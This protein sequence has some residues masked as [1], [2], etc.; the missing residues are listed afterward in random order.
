MTQG[1]LT[2]AL[3]ET[4]AWFGDTGTPR[5]TREVADA[6]G[7]GRRSTYDR[8]DRLVDR[9]HLE[10]KR[11]GASAR[12]WWRPAQS[13]TGRPAQSTTPDR[14]APE[15][16]AD[17]EPGNRECELEQYRAAVETIDDG[18]YVVDDESRFLLVNEAHAELTGY[19]RE[20]LLGVHASLV[21]TE[22]DLDRAKQHRDELETSGRAVATV[23]TELL[24]ADGRR[25]PV[26]TRFA[27]FPLGDDRYG[28]AGVVR[29][30]S[31]RLDHER[32][33]E[34]RVRQQE[35]VAELGHR[36]LGEQDVDDLLADATVRVAGV[37]GAD[38]CKVLDLDPAASTLRLRQGVGWDDGI[39]GTATVSADENDSQAAHTL[40][41]ERPVVVEDLAAE[42]RFSGPDL[43][44]GHDVRSGISVPIGPHDDPWGI[45]G[46]HDTDPRT[47][48]ERDV[49][50][51]QSV[52]NV[53][54]TAIERHSDERELLVQREQLTAL[55][56]LN[57]TLRETTEAVIE[58]S[59]REEV[60]RTV[61]E[62][63]AATDSYE[64]AWIGDVDVATDTVNLRTE[65]GVEGYL[66]DITV[67]VDPDDERSRGPTGRA[68][69][70]GEIQTTGDVSA[71]DDHDPWRDHVDQYDFRSSAAVPITHG[72]T[73]YGVLNV[74][75][76][77]RRAFAGPESE[78]L[79]QLGEIVGHAIA[80]TDRKQTLMGDRL[81]EL[82]FQIR[83]VF[84]TLDVPADPR[85]TIT[86]DHT[87]RSATTSSSSTG[88]PRPTPWTPSRDSSRR[89]PT[90]S[91]SRSAGQ[92]A[93]STR[94]IRSTT[95]RDWPTRRSSRSSP[96]A[97]GRYTGPPSRTVTTA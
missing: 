86:L 97:A 92:T 89:F 85:G 14:Q 62:H 63:L 31:D 66:E 87:S 65:A 35:A 50:F 93:R 79:T 61:C 64:F 88:P 81:V 20:E 72:D 78:V 13:T 21:T 71:A 16:N 3:E 30:I 46:V 9:G 54:G 94:S 96:P 23:E 67:T 59:T 68:L 19:D 41:A 74:Y 48:S 75:A 12:V 27:L 1:S 84:A 15:R 5:T 45:L 47:F 51:V 2:D 58:Q 22:D 39:V 11:V 10:T 82:E 7:L 44:T 95:R 42:T 53:L 29:D 60:E 73:T 55:D 36:A 69:L 38:Y 43:L 26:E 91:Q 37:L 40:A 28:R 34:R 4:L 8:L 57:R 17:T 6:L 25:I 32:E 33:L 77:R 24:T 83:D 49:A 56:N 70:T 52:A 90:G 76:G 80:A 18:V